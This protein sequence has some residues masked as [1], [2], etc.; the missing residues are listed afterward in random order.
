VNQLILEVAV[1][2]A[3]LMYRK[4]ARLAFENCD[5]K[6]KGFQKCSRRGECSQLGLITFL[7]RD[8][9]RWN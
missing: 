8:L 6:Y 7:W 4:C 1:L 9:V 3:Q 5:H 2:S